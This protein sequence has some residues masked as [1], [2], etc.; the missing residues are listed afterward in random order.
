MKPLFPSLP[1]HAS[2]WVWVADRKLD[3][4]ASEEVLERLRSFLGAWTSHGR[5]VRGD[6][7]FIDHTILLIAG[8][9]E[10]GDI[11]GCGIDKSVHAIESAAAD[12]G[13][14]WVSGLDVVFSR[15]EDAP[16]ETASRADFRRLAKTGE[17]GAK[18]VIYERSATTLGRLRS[19]GIATAASDTWTARY[20]SGNAEEIRNP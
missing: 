6:A 9:V 11:S 2:L 3:A 17:L 16:I 20:F 19:Q 14:E 13:F 4:E 10:A 18:T 7:A 5:A 8:D 12:L 15:S 1:D